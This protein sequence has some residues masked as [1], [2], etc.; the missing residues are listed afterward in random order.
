MS[1]NVELH[2]AASWQEI[3]T[4]SADWQAADERLL[5]RMLHHM[6][7]IRAFEETV[8][9]LAVAGLVHGPAHSSIG[10][11][12][13]AV[14]AMASLS[15]VDQINGSH[16]AHHQFLA[17]A[18]N[19]VVPAEYDPRSKGLPPPALELLR[20]TLAEI[21]GLAQ[22]FCKGRGGSMHLRWAEA[23]ILGTNA[24]VG[25]GVPHAAG[26]AWAQERAGTGGVVVTF[27]GDGAVNI[28]AVPETMNLAAVWDLPLCFFIE[29][30]Q[31]A[32]ATT[33]A[34]STRETR[35]SAGSFVYPLF[36]VHGQ[37]V[38]E[39]HVVHAPALSFPPAAGPFCL[40]HGGAVDKPRASVAP[41][42]ELVQ[43]GR[44]LGRAARVNEEQG[45]LARP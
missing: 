7:L 27:L 38:R 32:V 16:R 24:I 35:L 36:V 8:L 43:E 10:Q 2:P 15:D 42:R 37:D 26:V 34:E 18:L 39:E 31:Y 45:M 25:G 12:G 3:R 17:K 21:M 20:R 13:G 33:V 30:N 29:N 22:G 9:E 5:V 1:E 11:E 14:G 44:F 23:G 28:G 6:V 41:S 40:G 4:T 19:Y